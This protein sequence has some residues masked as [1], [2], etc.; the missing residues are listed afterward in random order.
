M[1]E[2]VFP[3]G[4]SLRILPAVAEESANAESIGDCCYPN[5]DERDYRKV[6]PESP[7]LSSHRGRP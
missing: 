7:L 2:L 5:G 3:L 1:D 4:S 6:R